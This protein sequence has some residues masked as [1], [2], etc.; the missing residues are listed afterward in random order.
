[1]IRDKGRGLYEL[2]EAEITNELKSQGVLLTKRMKIK[3]NGNV[4]PTNTYI[5]DFDTPKPPE[6]IKI[7]YYSLKVEM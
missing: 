1:V 4:I 3:K 6:K 2:E 7:G 5:L